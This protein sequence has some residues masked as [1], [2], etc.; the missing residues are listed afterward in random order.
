MTTVKEYFEKLSG[1]CE[2]CEFKSDCSYMSS[3][4]ENM[5]DPF[6]ATLTEDD[7]KLDIEDFI[8]KHNA[9][10]RWA[11]ERQHKIW[12]KEK[13]LKE[14]R[15]EISFKRRKTLRIT[16]CQRKEITMLKREQAEQRRIYQYNVSMAEAFHFTEKMI[17]NRDIPINVA[18]EELRI[19]TETVI[20]ACDDKI[21]Q[22]KNEIKNIKKQ[23]RG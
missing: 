15:K 13:L 10:I 20:K 8:H 22:L 12:E 19:K 17:N 7:Y 18:L 1:N 2:N 21:L 11:E 3:C 4:H 14:K 23:N 9:N 5:C 6:C 16:Y